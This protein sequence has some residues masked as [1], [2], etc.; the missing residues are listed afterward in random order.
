MIVWASSNLSRKWVET[1]LRM[2]QDKIDANHPPAP[3]S[4]NTFTL[5]FDKDA[6]LTHPASCL[7]YGSGCTGY[8]PVSNVGAGSFRDAYVGTWTPDSDMLNDC[9]YCTLD[10]E[11]NEVHRLN[12]NNLAQDVE[13]SVDLSGE[14]AQLDVMFCVPKRYILRTG[15]YITHSRLPFEG[16]EPLAHTVGDEEYDKI[17]YGVYPTSV[18]GG[19]AYS[20]SGTVPERFRTRASFRQLAQ[21]KNGTVTNGGMWM[22]WNWHQ[23]AL[24][25]DMTLFALKNFNVQ[26]QLGC[27]FSAGGN[28]TNYSEHLTGLTNGNSMFCGNPNAGLISEDSRC[29]LESFWANGWQ[30]IDDMDI[31]PGYVNSS[32]RKNVIEVYA[33]HNHPDDI[34][35]ESTP[36]NN[37]AN[38]E[39]IGEFNPPGLPS[40]GASAYYAGSI[41]TTQEGWGLPL[42]NSG[43]TTTGTC[44]NCWTRGGSTTC[45]VPLVG[46]HSN[47]NLDYGISAWNIA[48]DLDYT[49]W[50]TG[51]RMVFL[52]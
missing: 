14:I 49:G 52:R 36:A 10:S 43:S 29:F 15:E 4:E 31:N 22:Q 46:G 27:G 24:M 16:G 45:R 11:G 47:S 5:Q 34:V 20:S 21:S 38:K 44:D 26:A 50:D 2:L 7:T 48:R 41:N 12:P 9:Y 25:R 40:S 32:P 6:L 35:C 37:N 19:K 17:Y 28:S 42:G 8:I 33:G 51:S 39:L 30:Y 13:G 18:R 1:R 3:P 23:F